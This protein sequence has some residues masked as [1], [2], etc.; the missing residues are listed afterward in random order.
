M[1]HSKEVCTEGGL[2]VDDIGF[3]PWLWIFEVTKRLKIPP[4]RA[5]ILTIFQ[6]GQQLLP[7]Q[8]V[9]FEKLNNMLCPTIVE[10]LP[11]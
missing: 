10:K 1:L 3:Y 9:L 5:N 11:S 7:T 2:S 6:V 8:T 4:R